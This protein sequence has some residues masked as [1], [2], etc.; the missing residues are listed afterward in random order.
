MVA[1]TSFKYW[2]LIAAQHEKRS[3]SCFLGVPDSSLTV[4][5]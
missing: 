5:I 3:T 1:V 4:L 2:V